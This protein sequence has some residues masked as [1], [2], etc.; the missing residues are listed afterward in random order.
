TASGARASP[1]GPLKELVVAAG[2]KASRPAA[3]ERSLN[4]QQELSVASVV[5]EP[6]SADF[7][8]RSVQ[9]DLQGEVSAGAGGEG[10]ARPPFSKAP[11]SVFM[12]M[13]ERARNRQV[14]DAKSTTVASA[15]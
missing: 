10:G 14:V 12:K 7:Y 2:A 3:A 5:V 11:S 1:E 15:K 6:S 4:F 13:A 8:E 9:T